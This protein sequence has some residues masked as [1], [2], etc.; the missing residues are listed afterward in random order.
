MTQNFATIAV[1]RLKDDKY[2][3]GCPHFHWSHNQLGGA[4]QNTELPIQVDTNGCPKRPVTCRAIPVG[5]PSLDLELIQQQIGQLIEALAFYA[6]GCHYRRGPE[7]PEPIAVDTG[8]HASETLANMGVTSSDI[9][10]IIR[11]QLAQEQ[12]CDPGT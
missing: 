10:D 5:G 7:D 9:Q 11:R 12:G 4:C 2:C 3:V 1:F 6:A 8:G